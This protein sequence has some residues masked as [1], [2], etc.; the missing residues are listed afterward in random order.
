MRALD[1]IAIWAFTNWLS[2]LTTRKEAF[3][4]LTRF[5]SSG[6]PAFHIHGGMNGHVMW[7]PK[8]RWRMQR[9]QLAASASGGLF[10]IPVHPQHQQRP[11]HSMQRQ[12]LLCSMPPM[13][14]SLS[15]HA[16]WGRH[17]CPRQLRVFQPASGT[18]GAATTAADSSSFSADNQQSELADEA[19]PR[20]SPLHQNVE[21]FVARV[22]PTSAEKEAKQRVI[23]A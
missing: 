18:S 21:A 6:G 16:S 1:A 8:A 5:P 10:S 14:P 4:C 20:Y 13:L 22:A 17:L 11:R 15:C 7:L 23:E 9:I 3:L 2:S 19:R 12:A